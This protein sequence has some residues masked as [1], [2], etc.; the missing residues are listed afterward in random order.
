MVAKREI[1]KIHWN[2][3]LALEEDFGRLSRFVELC[4]EN[5][6]V[7]SIEIARLFLSA[8]FEVDVVLKQICKKIDSNATPKN[9]QCY[10]KIMC[11]KL[12]NFNNFKDFEVVIPFYEISIQPWL[13]WCDDKPPDWW[14]DHNKV[15]HQRH[16][17]F[18]RANLKNCVHSLAGLF[19]AILH[20]YSEDA[21]EGTLVPAPKLFNVEDRFFGGEKTGSFGKSYLYNI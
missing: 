2:Y 1:K 21:R 13:N 4:V 18:N 6:K 3:F 20:L 7:Y 10:R 15:K 17:H 11:E 12:D 9:I 5:N 14:S 8:C 16:E 19:V